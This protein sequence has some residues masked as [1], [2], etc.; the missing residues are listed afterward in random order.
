VRIVIDTIPHKQQ[1]YDTVGDWRWP[2]YCRLEKRI[3]DPDLC[4]SVSNLG[5]WRMEVLIAVHE[6]IEALLCKTDGVSE[7]EVDYFDMNW[8]PVKTG[9]TSIKEVGG[10]AMGFAVTEYRGCEEPGDDPDAPYYE[11]H[12]RASGYERLLAADL[13][14]NWA[15][16]EQALDAL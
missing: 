7:A 4:I 3:T 16:Y 10:A 9:P 11:Q 1:R 12:Q 6:L 13:E 15:E 5:D 2:N 14:V 8:S